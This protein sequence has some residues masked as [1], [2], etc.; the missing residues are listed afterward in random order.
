MNRELLPVASG[1]RIRVVLAGLLRERR[2]VV[3]GG[4]LALLASAGASMAVAPLLG[5]VVDVVVQRR[6]PDAVTA[7]VLGLVVAALAQGAL[8]VLGGMLVARAGEG[9]LADLRER[10]VARALS[11][12]LARVE[13]AGAGDLTSRVTSDLSLV[14]DAVREAVPN[15]ARGGLVILATLVGLAA[16]DWRFLLAAL[17]ALPVQALTA[18]WYLRRSTPLYAEQR[19]VGGAQ[20]QQLLDTVGGIGTVRSLVLHDEHRRRVSSRA[21][22]V[23]ALALRVVRLQTGFFGRLNLAEFLGIAAVLATGTWLVSIDAASVGTASAAAL[24]F[25][26]LFTPINETLFLLDTVQSAGASLARVVG[27]ADLEP[28]PERPVG[29]DGSVAVRGVRHS[30]VAGHEVLSDVD[31]DIPAGARVA[32]V[33]ASG[34]GKTTLAGL[35]AGVHVPTAGAVAAGR[36]GLV[37]QEVHVFAGPLADDLRLAAPSASDDDLAAAVEAVGASTWVAAL[38]DGIDTVVGAGG[39]ALTG[40]Q[41]QQL[42]LARL[43]LADPPVA[44]LDEATAEAGSSGARVLDEAAERVLVGRTGIVVAHRLV[45]AATADRIVVMDAGRIVESGTHDELLAAGGRYAT[46]WST[47]QG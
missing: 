15:V 21:A 32:L 7:P 37:T 47:Q 16:L 27:V 36:V 18:R 8:A 5:L 9:L 13:E 3:L 39:H 31:L 22:D 25:I 6:G 4:L 28:A 45:Q 35:V 23:V 38:P 46:L 33:G 12:P 42:A 10:F 20:Q 14:G 2:G 29:E 11:L 26:A 41:A 19:R 24:Y 40:A 30:Y 1:D 34:A 44:V 43:L 17:V